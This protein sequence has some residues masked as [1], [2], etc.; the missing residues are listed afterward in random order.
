MSR[1]F[2]IGARRP[3]ES[4]MLRLALTQLSES[5]NRLRHLL[6]AYKKA[7]SPGLAQQIAE[8]CAFAS[9]TLDWL[10]DLADQQTSTGGFIVPARMLTMSRDLRRLI[11]SAESIIGSRERNHDDVA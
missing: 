1:E 8:E 10:T 3:H 5:E 4:E 9:M 6:A 7:E 11:E 2:L